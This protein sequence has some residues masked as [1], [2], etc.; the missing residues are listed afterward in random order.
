[1]VTRLCRSGSCMLDPVST[2]YWT[3]DNKRHSSLHCLTHAIE[4]FKSHA[5]QEPNMGPIP[6]YY[7]PAPR[8]AY[9]LF[10]SPRPSVNHKLVKLKM[11]ARVGNRAGQ[12]SLDVL[13][14]IV[15]ITLSL[16]IGYVL[17]HSG[18]F[19]ACLDQF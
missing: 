8:K 6:Q 14:V 12:A 18:G 15:L 16:V 1:M 9:S 13:G 2:V 11:L 3:V 7:N 19:Q 17:G 5:G 10:P 4:E